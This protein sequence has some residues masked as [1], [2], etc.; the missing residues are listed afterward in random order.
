MR[1]SL[2]ALWIIFSVVKDLFQG[3]NYFEVDYY[4]ML[5]ICRRFGKK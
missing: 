4:G 3:L 2:T 1:F 5:T